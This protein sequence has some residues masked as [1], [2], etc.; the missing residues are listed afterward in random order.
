MLPILSDHATDYK[1]IIKVGIYDVYELGN[2]IVREANNIMAMPTFLF[3]RN[4]VEV[5]RHIGI[6]RKEDMKAW[7]EE[8][9][10]E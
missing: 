2:E 1:D 10:S 8:L 7:F 9:L 6:C 3:L 4:G 5:A